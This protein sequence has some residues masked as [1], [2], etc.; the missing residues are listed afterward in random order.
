MT[1]YEQLIKAA[2]Q[3]KSV[4]INLNTK[5]ARINGNE[6]VKNGV[7]SGDY[8]V[9]LNNPKEMVEFLFENYFYSYPSARSS[10]RKSYFIAQEFE[11]LSTK[12][13]ATSEDRI[14]AQV[15]LEAYVLG[16]ILLGCPFSAFDTDEKHWFWQS[17]NNKK[18]IIQREWFSK[19]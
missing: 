7:Y 3:G 8:G 15:K 17:S 18:L 12:Q 10:K 9:T 5:S 1:I 11:K 13:L 4:F 6:I 16:L 2:E 19:E 14:L